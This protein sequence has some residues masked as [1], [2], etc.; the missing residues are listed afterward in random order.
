MDWWRPQFCA[1]LAARGLFVLRYDQR[2]TGRSTHDLPGSPSYGLPVMVTDAIAILDAFQ[3]DSAHLVGFSSG[4]WVAQ[5]AALDHP[6]RVDSL[7]LLSSRPTGHGPADPDLPEVSD[8]LF[9]E[10]ASTAEPDWDDPAAVLDYLVEGERAYAAE[11]F[12][13]AAVRALYEDVLARSIDIRAAIT[14]HPMADQGPRWRERLSHVDVPTVVISGELD[15]LFAPANAEALKAEIPGATL[16]VLPDVGHELPARRWPD[17]L[18]AITTNLARCGADVR[19][20][21]W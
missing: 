4:G 6:D 7:A 19:P 16:T 3:L 10:W 2:D 1:R 17:Y 21:E 13:V 11:P 12:D 5:L 20:R 8:R 18:S 9:A 14:N 15:P